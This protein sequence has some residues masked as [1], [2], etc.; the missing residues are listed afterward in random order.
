MKT[1][2]K[3]TMNKFPKCFPKN[4]EEDILPK[5]IEFKSYK[6]YRILKLGKLEHAAFIS[7]FEEY[8]DSTFKPRGYNPNSASTYST[9]VFSDIQETKNILKLMCKHFPRPLISEGSTEPECGPC[10]RDN[11]SSHIDWWIYED[12]FPEKIFKVVEQ[13]V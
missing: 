5:D 4:F 7:T 10:K 3:R 8:K 6:A 9:S 12:T 1:T 13:D 2:N 11:N